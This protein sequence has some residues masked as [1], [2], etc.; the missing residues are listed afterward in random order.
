MMTARQLFLAVA[1]VGATLIFV[2]HAA[3]PARR[4]RSSEGASIK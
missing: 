1:S 4:P 3:M 2:G